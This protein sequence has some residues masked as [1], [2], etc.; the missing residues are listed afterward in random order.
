MAARWLFLGAFLLPLTAAAAGLYKHVDARG[1]VTYTDR[2]Q[3]PGQAALSLAPVNVATPEARRQ[4][5]LARQRMA[6]EEQAE[7]ALRM[8]QW[9]AAQRAAPVGYS[10]PAV[11]PA[12]P[13]YA[14][15]VYT[16]VHYHP[17][18][19]AHA[20]PAANAAH[21]RRSFSSERQSFSPEKPRHRHTSRRAG[22]ARD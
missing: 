5:E 14:A 10:P 20:I 4:L 1:H 6:R 2:P 13:L 8:Q 19:I 16:P 7:F 9:S 22:R 12:A 15:P 17:T 3:Q 18:L 11:A 21:P